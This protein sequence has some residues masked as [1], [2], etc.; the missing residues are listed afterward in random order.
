[1]NLL[2]ILFFFCCRTELLR[3]G[4]CQGYFNPF[5]NLIG[6]ESLLL[7]AQRHVK[8]ALELENWLKTHSDVA[9]VSYVGL[10]DHPTYTNAKKYS[11][12]GYGGSYFWIK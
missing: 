11:R 9:W 1:M 12:N 7:R 8:N 3:I 4:P 10:P 5:A 2:E 6:L